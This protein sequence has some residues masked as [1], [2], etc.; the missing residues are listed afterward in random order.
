MAFSP[1]LFDFLSDSLD[2][3][4]DVSSDYFSDSFDIDPDAPDPK[5]LRVEKSYDSQA[6]HFVVLAL[7]EPYGTT[8]SGRSKEFKGIKGK[9]DG[10]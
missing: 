9:T 2:F 4:P 6:L 1:G 10:N 8:R 3:D 5:D 7:K